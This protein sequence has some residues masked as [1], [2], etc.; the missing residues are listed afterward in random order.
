MSFIVIHWSLPNLNP[1]AIG[2]TGDLD[3]IPACQRQVAEWLIIPVYKVLLKPIYQ[4]QARF[5]VINFFF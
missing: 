1:R 2:H 5:H 3:R 4:G